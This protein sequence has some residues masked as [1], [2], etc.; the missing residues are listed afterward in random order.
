MS[1]GGYFGVFR[2]YFKDRREERK[3]P[4]L[5]NDKKPIKK[6]QHFSTGIQTNYFLRFHKTSGQGFADQCH[7]FVDM[8]DYRHRITIWDNFEHSQYA[9]ISVFED[10]FLFGI[11]QEKM[12]FCSSKVGE[13][14]Y[15]E[16]LYTDYAE[17]ELRVDIGSANA[18]TPLPFTMKVKGIVENAYPM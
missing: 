15:T 1:A 18:K 8:K 12:R 13:G 3:T 10:L 7:G 11:L 6:Q 16:K 2:E 9:K 17:Q 4:V 14:K 5:E